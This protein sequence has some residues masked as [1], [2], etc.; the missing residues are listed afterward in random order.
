ML[1]CN[2]DGM[3][4][5]SAAARDKGGVS[6]VYVNYDRMVVVCHGKIDCR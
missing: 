3:F 5:G 6:V 2:G 4:G 1:S